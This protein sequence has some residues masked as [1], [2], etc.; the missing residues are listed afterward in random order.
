MILSWVE[1]DDRLY[2]GELKG[3][4]KGDNFSDSEVFK[5]IKKPQTVPTIANINVIETPYTNNGRL[6]EKILITF[7][8]SIVIIIHHLVDLILHQPSFVL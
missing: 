6:L 3:N 2:R 7:E 1:L 8:K 5:P 4:N